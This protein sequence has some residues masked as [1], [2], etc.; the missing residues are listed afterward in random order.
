M[1]ER[2][3]NR[4]AGGLQ[5]Y[6]QECNQVIVETLDLNT[7]LVRVFVYNRSDVERNSSTLEGLR[8]PPTPAASVANS[9][10]FP[11]RHGLSLQT[12]LISRATSTPTTSPSL[13]KLFYWMSLTCSTHWSQARLDFYYFRLIMVEACE[14]FISTS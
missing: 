13:S 7:K 3:W 5:A 9:L 4:Q 2:V 1:I 14:S 10:G 8:P 6:E 11:T 12:C